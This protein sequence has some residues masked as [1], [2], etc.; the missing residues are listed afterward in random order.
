MKIT[1]KKQ[2][3][4]AIS[5]GIEQGFWRP[6]VI[7]IITIFITLIIFSA[8]SILYNKYEANAQYN[9]C[10]K[11]PDNIECALPATTEHIQKVEIV[12]PEEENKPTFNQ[13]Y[14]WVFEN[15]KSE[16]AST[17]IIEIENLVINPKRGQIENCSVDS[18]VLV[19]VDGTIFCNMPARCYDENNSSN[20]EE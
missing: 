15:Q 2:L 7:M 8:C 1:E 9:F 20:P 18:C 3:T 5:E 11:D 13:D 19:S 6:L 17:N 14:Y 10:V 12:R 4:Q 16:N